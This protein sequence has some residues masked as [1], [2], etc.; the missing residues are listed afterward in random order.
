MIWAPYRLRR[1][2]KYIAYL[3]LGYSNATLFLFPLGHKEVVLY[4]GLEAFMEGAQINILRV[5]Q[6]LIKAHLGNVLFSCLN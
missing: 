2:G 3:I 6:D 1:A 4:I 5:F